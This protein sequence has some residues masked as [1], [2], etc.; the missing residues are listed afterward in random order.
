MK[1]IVFDGYGQQPHATE[2]PTPVPGE[3][4]VLVRVRATSINP[5]DWKQVSGKY[6]PILTASFPFIPSYDLAG[7]VEA[8]GPGVT[9]LT[10]GQRVHTRLSGTAGGANA[11]YVRA[12]LDVLRPMPPEMPFDQAAGLPLAGMTALQGL[13]DGC[14]LPM[15]GAK[16]RVLIVG[17]SGGVG[18]LAVQIA[19]AAG[20]H[21]TGVCS[22]RNSELVRSL[23]ADAIVDYTL[24]DA[25][26]N[27]E[28]FDVV[29]DC[30]G[31]APSEFSKRM[32]PSGRYASSVP[33]PA[34]LAR[35]AVNAF[36]KQKV[37]GVFL[38]SNGADLGLLDALFEQKKLKVVIDNRFSAEQ[39]ADAFKRSESGRAVGKIVV[40]W[41]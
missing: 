2:V 13:R 20:A 23:G 19:K 26:R 35:Q 24:P 32:R 3:G 1:A 9:G 17:A 34:V 41:D 11:Q 14:G 10:R 6:R 38:K 25:W 12:S 7:E 31:G 28:P 29:L 33:G 27:V 30:V 16:E 22:G 5:I 4:E 8:L 18:H 37:V 36:S 15:D 40:T 39:L 21:V